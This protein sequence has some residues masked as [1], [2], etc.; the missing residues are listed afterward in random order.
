M[1][2]RSNKL[3]SIN[4]HFQSF[5]SGEEKNVTRKSTYK[6]NLTCTEIYTQQTHKFPPTCFGTSWVPSSGVFTVVKVTLS[7]FRN[8]QQMHQTLLVILSLCT[9]QLACSSEVTDELPVD[10]TQLPKHVG[11]AK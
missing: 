11:A 3:I 10:G 2:S 4:V 9:L 1:L 6:T 8:N 7:M 5:N